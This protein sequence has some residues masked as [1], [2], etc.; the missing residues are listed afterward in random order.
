MKIFFTEYFKQQLKKLMKKFPHAD[1]DLLDAL[2][3]L[4]PE[5][6]VSIG[7]SIYKIRTGSSD[8]KKGKSGSFRTYI[9][10]YRQKNLLVPLCIYAKPEQVSISENE[11]QYHV[12]KMNEE[13]LGEIEKN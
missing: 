1:R 11:L 13:L 10:F 6:E 3:N 5:N 7:K 2:E 12:D 8:M 4:N 9:Y